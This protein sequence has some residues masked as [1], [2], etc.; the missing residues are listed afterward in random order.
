MKVKIDHRLCTGD[1]IC[2]ELCPEVFVLHGDRAKV[3]VDEIPEE[4][5]ESCQDAITSCPESCIL[6]IDD[7]D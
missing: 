5:E 2:V 1:A 7:A 6:V 3:I 4:L